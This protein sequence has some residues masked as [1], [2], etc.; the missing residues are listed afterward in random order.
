M[1]DRDV[2]LDTLN[3]DDLTWALC[4]VESVAPEIS[5]QLSKPYLH[6]DEF[7]CETYGDLLDAMEFAATEQLKTIRVSI[8]SEFERE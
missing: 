6:S 5:L 2:V 1:M 7:M 3:V 8:Y 4:F